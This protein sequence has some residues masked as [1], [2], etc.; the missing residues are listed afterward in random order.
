MNIAV[1]LC[2]KF[3]APQGLSLGYAEVNSTVQILERG[4]ENMKKLL[5]AVVL[6]LSVATMSDAAYVNIFNLPYVYSPNSDFSPFT[7][8]T[9]DDA[10]LNQ[11]GSL[12]LGKAYDTLDTFVHPESTTQAVGIY[13]VGAPLQST[14]GG[15]N[16]F[17]DYHLKTYDDATYD[18]FR[19][20]VTESNYLWDGG[21]EVG[22]W[23]WGGPIVT[24]LQTADAAPAFRGFV[25]VAGGSNYYLNAVLVTTS[26]T[27][28]ASWGRISDIAVEVVAPVPEA[29]AIL[30]LGSGLVGLVGYRRL[31]RMI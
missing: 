11:Y 4:M 20:V 26:Y 3:L 22:G 21:T 30:L 17:F 16:L 28:A 18:T 25:D 29:S 2:V 10:F 1:F 8:P 6:M 27:L 15:Y 23:T 31:K 9:T 19:V 13:G 5:M 7:S 24:T 14:Y 12:W